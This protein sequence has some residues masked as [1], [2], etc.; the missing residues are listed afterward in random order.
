MMQIY[1][2]SIAYLIIGSGLLLV[3]Y[4][5]GKLLVFL[6]VKTL[7]ASSSWLQMS[8]VLGG[9]LLALAQILFPVSP[10]PI[11][12]GDILPAAV[13]FGLAFYYLYGSYSLKKQKRTGEEKKET[14][15][16][17][18]LGEDLI[19]KTGGLLEANKRIFGIVVAVV[20]T[21]HFLFPSLVL[22]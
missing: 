11:I 2:L 19:E 12:L 8:L 16:P 21:I 14:S 5:G 17:P 9:L 22:V 7:F 18:T 1:L 4:Y 6:R 10:G 13:C 15:T 20:A 3:D